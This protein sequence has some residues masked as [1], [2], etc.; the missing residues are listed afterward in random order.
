LWI[1]FALLRCRWCE[2]RRQSL[3]RRHMVVHWRNSRL[4][5]TRQEIHGTNILFIVQYVIPCPF[6]TLDFF[7]RPCFFPKNPNMQSSQETV[8]ATSFLSKI[9]QRPIKPIDPS[10]IYEDALPMIPSRPFTLRR[11]LNPTSPDSTPLALL[12]LT[13]KILKPSST[14]TL[15][16]IPSDMLVSA[17]KAKIEKAR[18]VCDIKLIL[19]VSRSF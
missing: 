7:F 5:E 2:Y 17:L 6:H 13:F 10:L 16:S 15:S 19:K 3:P 9:S 12:S 18:G 1:V 8:F 11:A 4:A 14:F